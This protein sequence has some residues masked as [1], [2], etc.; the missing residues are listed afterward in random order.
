MC[1]CLR[2]RVLFGDDTAI[3]KRMS[4]DGVRTKQ[5]SEATPIEHTDGE[6]MND[7]HKSFSQFCFSKTTHYAYIERSGKLPYRS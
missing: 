5:P 4:G 2:E 6:T 1:V 7:I 3:E